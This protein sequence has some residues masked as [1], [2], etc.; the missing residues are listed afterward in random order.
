MADTVEKV[1]SA[2][3][4][5]FLDAAGEPIGKGAGSLPANASTA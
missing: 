5:K 3:W 2:G 4:S 1:F